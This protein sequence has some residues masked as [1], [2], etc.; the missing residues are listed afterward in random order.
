MIFFTA[1]LHIGHRN[2]LRLCNRPFDNIEQHDETIVTNHNSIVSKNDIVYVL[3]DFSYRC[4]DVYAVEVLRRLNGK[5][6][7]LWGNHDKCLRSALKKNMVNDLLNNGNLE[8]IGSSD[9]TQSTSLE[10]NVNGQIIVLSHY[11]MRSWHHAFR[12]SWHLYGHSHGRLPSLY[13][14]MDVGVD[15]NNF[16]PYDFNWIKKVMSNVNEN[17]QE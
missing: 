10:I 7:I 12:D 17:F 3:G 4:S 5:H 13:K 15:T 2:I 9:H 1:D 16:Y 11:A 14:S 8:F 6:I